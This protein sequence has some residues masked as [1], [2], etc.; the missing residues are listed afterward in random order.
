MSGRGQGRRAARFARANLRG[1]IAAILLGTGV[2]LVGAMDN[3]L[4]HDAFI[5]KLINSSTVPSNGDVNPYGVAFVPDDF[6]TGGKILEGD[7]LA[8][9]FNNSTNTQGTG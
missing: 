8:A 3:A 5:P 9:N 6:P 2:A 4:A 1:A 7:V